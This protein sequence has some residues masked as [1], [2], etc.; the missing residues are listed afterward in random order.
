LCCNKDASAMPALFR[1]LVFA[2][3]PLA[4]A[5]AVPALALPPAGTPFPPLAPFVMPQFPVMIP[6]PGARSPLDGVTISTFVT[7][8]KAASAPSAPLTI[9]GARASY[10]IDLDSRF[11][12]PLVRE[13]P[14]Q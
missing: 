9:G 13:L 3:W 11:D 5:Y 7:P 2:A 4:A 6:Q 10:V 14:P 1:R 8:P 12:A